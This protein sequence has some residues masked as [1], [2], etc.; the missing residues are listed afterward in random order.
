MSWLKA[1]LANESNLAAESVPS[2]WKLT[3]QE[4]VNLMNES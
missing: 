3:Q 2:E 4:K 1:N